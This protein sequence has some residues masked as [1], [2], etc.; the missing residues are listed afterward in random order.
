MLTRNADFI[1]DSMLSLGI[2]AAFALEIISSSFEL[3]AGS[4]PFSVP[5]N[6]GISWQTEV[7]GN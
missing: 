2:L 3:F 6:N 4:A 5:K 1:A 7:A